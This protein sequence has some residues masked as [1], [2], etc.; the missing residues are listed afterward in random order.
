M[1]RLNDERPVRIHFRWKSGCVNH[2]H[3]K[4]ER[5]FIRDS[6][7]LVVDDTDLQGTLI[8]C[9]DDEWFIGFRARQ[10]AVREDGLI[11]HQ[12][13][14][15]SGGARYRIDIDTRLCIG[16]GSELHRARSRRQYHR[17]DKRGENSTKDVYTKTV[18]PSVTQTLGCSRSGGLAPL[19]AKR[20]G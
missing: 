10:G 4:S 18:E 9:L 17:G 8:S 1:S 5:G 14:N 7:D 19:L 2:R 6:D 12:S 11:E 13:V 15:T 20:G 3:R 16:D